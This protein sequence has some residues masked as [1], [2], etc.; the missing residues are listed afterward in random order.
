MSLTKK[1]SGP[2][3]LKARLPVVALS[4]VALLLLLF[5][6]NLF[7]AADDQIERLAGADRYETAAQI[8]LKLSPGLV[9]NVVLASGQ[10]FADA[11]AGVPFA[12]QKYAPIL[13]VEKVPKADDQAVKYI[14]E[15]LRVNG[16]VYIL[17]GTAVISAACEQVLASVGIKAENIVRIAGSDRYETAVEIAKNMIHS[18]SEYYLVSG[19]NFPDALSASVLAATTGFIP[20]DEAAY[21]KTKGQNVA[22]NRG[23]VPV[24]LL[25]SRGGLPQSV[26][27]YL[28]TPLKDNTLK[29]TLRIV[30]GTG[31]VPESLVDELKEK[32]SQLAGDGVKRSGGENRYATNQILMQDRFNKAWK[33]NG[34]GLVIPQIVL[35]CGQNYPDAL[36]GAVLASSLKAPLVLINTAIPAE[37]AALL[38][39]YYQ[40][41][42]INTSSGTKM[43][44]LGGTGVVPRDTVIKADYLYNYGKQPGGPSVSTLAGTA[45]EFSLPFAAAEGPDGSIYVA[46]TNNHLIKKVTATGQVSVF[47]G[48]AGPS[49]TYGPAGGFADGPKEKARFNEPRGLA[50]DGQ[51]NL[52]VAD[53]G[54]GAIRMISP[55]GVVST[56]AKDLSLPSGLALSPDGTLYVTETMKHRVLEIKPDGTYSVV[57]GGNYPVNAGEW[58]GAYADGQGEKAQFNEPLGLALAADGTLY[59]ADSG[60]QRIRVIDS[61]KNVTTLAGS[62][63]EKLEDTSYLAG[64]YKDG[65]LREA[66]FNFPTGVALSADGKIYVADSCNNAIR[67]I[68]GE[69]VTTFSGSIFGKKDGYLDQ[70]LFNGPW[71]LTF[72]KNGRMLVVDRLNSLLRVVNL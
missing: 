11:L 55:K 51:G 67:V 45:N 2:R 23:G 31:A 10:G 9:N 21:L 36:A 50:F 30:G 49:G 72:L 29:Q 61:A 52:Y 56:L 19:E 17:G 3:Y 41:N 63:T 57:A 37:T 53:S 70:A 38:L 48:Q 71:S 35:A 27:D 22:A 14:K 25:P 5:P 16:K 33:E 42:T 68:S 12:H 34:A 62:G 20:A 64:G 24:L 40:E 1:R 44:V 60:N 8:A 7:A 39:D 32:V 69:N 43:Y 46:D 15:H 65:A 18:G 26:L 58:E 66:A 47:A 6:T 59:V 13:L 4:A 28:N 54:N